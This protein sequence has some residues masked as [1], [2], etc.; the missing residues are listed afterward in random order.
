MTTSNITPEKRKPKFSILRVLLAILVFYLVFFA[1]YPLLAPPSHRPETTARILCAVRLMTFRWAFE[2]Y[3]SDQDIK[4]YPSSEKWCDLL[5]ERTGSSKNR[6]LCQGA[7]EVGDKGPSH[8]AINPS[9]KPN[10][11]SDTVLLFETK[12]GWNQHGGPEI[13]TTEHHQNKGCNI[14]F[15]DGSV[16]FV[17]KEK[18]DELKWNTEEPNNTSLQGE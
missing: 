2:A 1:A 15:N 11:P 18:L 10:S 9:C 16:K 6:F 13:L 12:G 5:V 3:C 17:T 8:Y 4:T 7:M 14:L